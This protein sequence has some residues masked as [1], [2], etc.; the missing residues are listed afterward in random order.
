MR[1][2]LFRGS[3]VIL[4]C[5]RHLITI[6]LN[7]LDCIVLKNFFAS[8]DAAVYL[9]FQRYM[10]TKKAD[11]DHS[12][13][14]RETSAAST[15]M[16]ELFLEFM[17]DQYPGMK[18]PPNQMVALMTS[19]DPSQTLS[20]QAHLN[21]PEDPCEDVDESSDYNYGD[22]EGEPGQETEDDDTNAEKSD[23]KVVKKDNLVKTFD[24]WGHNFI[25]SFQIKVLKKPLGYHNLYH[26]TNTNDKSASL[27]AIYMGTEKGSA[28][29]AI[30]V[31]KS[32]AIN[33]FKSKIPLELN[34]WYS[35]QLEQKEKKLLVIEDQSLFQTLITNQ[36]EHKNVAFYQSS[37]WF[38]SLT[39]DPENKSKNIVEIRSF[40]HTSQYLN[41]KLSKN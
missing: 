7:T 16:Q 24:T 35:L 11:S 27:P 20:A 29:L 40:Q 39:Y 31:K 37:P 36:T 41:G 6:E 34:K 25:I 19:P 12:V 15:D 17:E 33:P 8:S 4:P 38:P 3:Q 13:Q 2:D 30:E 5:H 14:K 26:W 22:Y 28:Y 32:D 10:E 21:P 23:S 18:S 9:Q 1:R